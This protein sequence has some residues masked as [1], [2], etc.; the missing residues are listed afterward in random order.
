LRK[1]SLLVAGVALM[2]GTLSACLPG[3]PP[4]PPTDPHDVLVVGDS[5]AFSFGCVLGDTLPDTVGWD[6]PA[7]PGYTTKN[8]AVG[9]CTIYPT[10]VLLYNGG[11]AGVPNCDTFAAPPDNRTWEEAANFYVP[12][13]VI[14]NTA[15]WEIVDRWVDDFSGAPDSQWGAPGCSPQNACTPQY[16]KAAVQYSSK[17]YDAITMFRSKGAKVIVANAPYADGKAPVPDPGGGTPAGLECSW[18]E[19]YPDSVPTASGGNCTGNATPGTGG[20]WRPPYPGLT[21]RS[22]RAKLDQINTIMAFV[23]SQYFGGDPDVRIFPFK[24]HF[25]GPNNVYTSYVCAPPN[26]RTVAAVEDLDWHTTNPLDTAF[27]CDNGQG[28]NSA[29]NPWPYAILARDADRGHLSPAGA[30]E[31]LQPYI[32]PCVQALLGIGGD[33]SKCS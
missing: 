16:Q 27:Q 23:K 20:Q 6:C 2:A 19:P 30:F 14:I 21:Y 11:Q 28:P 9:A 29:L 32:E 4:P 15:G 25:N 13:V 33:L 31:I 12:K 1:L 8:S 10:S 22:S 3:P 18:W 24:D 26:D 5:V 17:L 7:R